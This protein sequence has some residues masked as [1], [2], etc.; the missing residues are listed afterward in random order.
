MKKFLNLYCFSLLFLLKS[1]PKQT[2]L[3]LKQLEKAAINAT[4]TAIK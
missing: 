1:Q 4:K 2:I 3:L